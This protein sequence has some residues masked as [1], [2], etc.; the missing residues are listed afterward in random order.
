MAIVMS[1]VFL[2]LNR[3]DFCG[4]RLLQIDQHQNQG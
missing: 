2:F 1:A 3:C 4:Y